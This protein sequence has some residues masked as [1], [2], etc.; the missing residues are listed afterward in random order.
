MSSTVT[1]PP[2]P[3]DQTRPENSNLW[4]G[5]V[6]VVVMLAFG[7]VVGVT[8]TRVVGESPIMSQVIGTLTSLVTIVVS[9]WM[10]SSSGSTAKSAQ[11]AQ[12][13]PPAAVTTTTASSV[14]S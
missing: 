1:P 5:I 10:G 3:P 2:P 9:Y 14:C 12:Y 11:L 6:S 13:M 4:R 7:A 8:I